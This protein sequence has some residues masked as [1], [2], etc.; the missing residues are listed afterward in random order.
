MGLTIQEYREK[1]KGQKRWSDLSQQEWIRLIQSGWGRAFQE[2]LQAITED[3]QEQIE[4]FRNL[5][6]FIFY[7]AGEG[8]LYRI[9]LDEKE[10]EMILR[11]IT[12]PGDIILAAY[13]GYLFIT[14][15]RG[16]SKTK[17]EHSSRR[18]TV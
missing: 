9:I 18:V 6:V 3:F 2:E 1:T 13:L 17:V 10:A 14:F 5:R 12:L 4:W 16:K 8:R 11:D 7:L 15:I